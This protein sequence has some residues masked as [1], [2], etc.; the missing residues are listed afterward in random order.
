[1][2]PRPQPLQQL[3]EAALRPVRGVLTDI[4]DTLTRDGAIDP[5]APAALHALRAAGVA[6]DRHHR[7][8][9]GLERA[10]RARLAG[11]RDRGRERRRG[12]DPRRRGG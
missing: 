10:L 1:M 12:A 8:A 9:D 5:A 11:G 2:P 4:D 7:P 6:G 3:S